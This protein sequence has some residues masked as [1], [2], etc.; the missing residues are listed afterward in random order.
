MAA[1]GIDLGTDGLRAGRMVDAQFQSGCSDRMPR[2][3]TDTGDGARWSFTSLKR[4]LD[5]DST[6]PDSVGG[7]GSIAYFSKLLSEIRNGCE[8]L[9]NGE[10]DALVA[11]PSCFS[12]RQRSVLRTAVGMAGFSRMRLANDALAMLFAARSGIE[13]C[14]S[15][16]VYSWG[17]GTFSIGFYEPLGP[18]FKVLGQDGDRLL[19]GDDLN[20]E[21]LRAAWQSPS[22]GPESPLRSDDPDVRL[23]ALA[24]IEEIKLALAAGES[25]T[26]Q[27]AKL[28]GV[29]SAEG[30]A[31]RI[32][33][34]FQDRIAWMM[35]AM[36]RLTDSTMA[37]VEG[38]DPDVVLLGG[39]MM[40]VPQVR[41][42]IERRF[43]GRIKVAAPDSVVNGC[44]LMSAAML[45]TEW[46]K[47]ELQQPATPAE[48]AAVSPTDA[49]DEK[50]E[51]QPPK[52]S[53][54]PK[55]SGSG[56]GR[57]AD[58][59]IPI[60]DEAE[61]LYHARDLKGTL[62]QFDRLKSE[63]DKFRS[64][65]Y[66]RQGMAFANGRQWTKAF[67]MLRTANKL[68]SAS[69]PI[70]ANLLAVTW[71]LVQEY[72]KRSRFK[73]L[74]GIAD[75]S[76][77][78]IQRSPDGTTRHRPDLSGL[79]LVKGQCLY[80]LRL[81]PEAR[82]ALL[83]SSRIDPSREESRALLAQVESILAQSRLLTDQTKKRKPGRNEP[84]WCGK[85]LKYKN[86]CYPREPGKMGDET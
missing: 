54:A 16:L 79:F 18:S 24:L 4:L 39:G 86:C 43:G 37:L 73:D 31:A 62:S 23:Q 78:A 1:I 5:F 74:M 81:Y 56:N 22:L 32:S 10:A 12:Q 17:A 25:I 48:Q 69:N 21:I 75:D 61:R 80:Q 45:D 6:V 85:P 71:Q 52:V 40:L 77:A 3:I 57:W 53:A 19:G 30:L 14:R 59:F 44:A 72:S 7:G 66:H 64:D 13:G 51:V 49:A 9:A 67:Q 70:L 46:E 8:D 84:C 33:G 29:E 83:E 15:V 58:N 34:C 42:I 28:A 20:S 47:L 50:I 2:L 63:I 55:E 82:D 26:D 36:S 27:A 65:F 38:A 60:F 35:A 41:D 76:I 11:V 68:A